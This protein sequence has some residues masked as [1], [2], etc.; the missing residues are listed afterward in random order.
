MKH[1]LNV[2]KFVHISFTSCF[3][4]YAHTYT[5]TWLCYTTEMLFFSEPPAVTGLQV[6]NLTSTIVHLLWSPLNCTSYSGSYVGYEI[7]L[8]ELQNY[9]DNEWTV[10]TSEAVNRTEKFF[11]NLV[12][13]TNYSFHVLFRNNRFSGP[14]SSITFMTV[15]DGKLYC[16]WFLFTALHHSTSSLASPHLVIYND[17]HMKLSFDYDHFL[18]LPKLKVWNRLLCNILKL[19]FDNRLQLTEISW[20]VT[21]RVALEF[22]NDANGKP[23]W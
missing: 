1:L 13:F 23:V 17:C 10:I 9:E 16:F 7:E 12:P 3:L 2:E 6:L 19:E 5:Y 14:K 8:S 11:P 21:W 22:P 20:T 4:A 18:L 15:E